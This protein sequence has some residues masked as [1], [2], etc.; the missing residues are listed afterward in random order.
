MWKGHGHAAGTW[1]YNKDTDMQSG[2]WHEHSAWTW[3]YSRDMTCIMDLDT[4]H[5]LGHAAGCGHAAWTW[6]CSIN[7]DL[8]QGQQHGPHWS[9]TMDMDMP[10]RYRNS[11]KTLVQHC[12]F[13]VSYKPLSV[14]HP[15]VG[16]VVSPSPLVTD[17]SVS[18]HCPSMA[19]TYTA[20]ICSCLHK[21]QR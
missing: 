8:H 15:H 17:E 1:T 2:H 18:A 12:W 7:M 19:A 5:G 3:I 14:R 13:S 6:T 9:C 11:E 21:L 16:I 4:Q 20:I 10:H